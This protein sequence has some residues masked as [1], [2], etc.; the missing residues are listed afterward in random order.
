MRSFLLKIGF[1]PFIA[2]FF[3]LSVLSVFV[4][5]VYINYIYQDGYKKIDQLKIDSLAKNEAIDEILDNA[6][7]Q[8][9]S[10]KN[11]L[12][13]GKD[14]DIYYEQ[15]SKYYETGRNTQRSLEKTYNQYETDDPIIIKLDKIRDSH[16]D[17]SFKLKKSLRTFNETDVEPALAASKFT[18][19]WGNNFFNS[20][21]VFKKS[22]TADA[23]K[24]IIELEQTITTTRQLAIAIISIL[25][26]FILIIFYRTLDKRL[27]APLLRMAEISS[28]FGGEYDESPSVSDLDKLIEQ[29]DRNATH[30]NQIMNSTGEAI[31]TLNQNGICTYANPACANILGYKD[32]RDLLGKNIHALIHHHYEDGTVHHEED[33]TIHIA[34]LEG[35]SC[36]KNDDV[37]WHSDGHCFPVDYRCYPVF[38]HDMITGSV[39]TFTDITVQRATQLAL[40]EHQMHLEELVD[41]RTSEL[42]NSRDEAI[43]ANLSKDAFLSQMSHELRTPLNA[44]L[45]FSQILQLNKQKNLTDTQFEQI[46]FIHNAGEHL[47]A[48]INQVLDLTQMSSGKFQIM[49]THFDIVQLVD[50]TVHV[51]QPITDKKSIEV[52]NKILDISLPDIYADIHAVKQVLINLIGNAAKYSPK[53]SEIIIS[54]SQKGNFLRINII[55]NGPGIEAKDQLRIFKPFERV[56]T[57]TFIEGSGIGLTVCQ[58]V[59]ELMGGKIGVE[60]RLGKGSNFWIDL[61]VSSAD[62]PEKTG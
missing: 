21:E 25:L 36:S 17:I 38:N 2:L 33:C 3:L 49:P 14:P 31:Y 15:L 24:R 10:F 45:G 23:Q 60:S 4:S 11:L 54:H 40:S 9:S 22:V 59:M 41:E 8:L 5:S 7:I 39:V 28:K 29:L 48:L 1:R 43:Q 55:D 37:F 44:I 57:N 6:I 35:N 46:D 26:F 56:T 18:E 16:S 58:N 34:M 52:I 27:T 53:G 50:E 19:D 61:P 51:M 13:L 30:I 32:P 47:L 42:E 20:I 12:I 62:I